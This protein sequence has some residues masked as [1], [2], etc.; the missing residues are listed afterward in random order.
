MKCIF[1][2]PMNNIYR[3]EQQVARKEKNVES[4]ARNTN[5]LLMQKEYNNGKATTE[6]TIQK[7]TSFSSKSNPKT[8]KNKNIKS[9]TRPTWHRAN[10]A[11]N[12][13]F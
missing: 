8:H 5:S 6:Y 10:E 12:R 11:A 1:P 3:K 4:N 2:I 9:G 7:Y 13:W